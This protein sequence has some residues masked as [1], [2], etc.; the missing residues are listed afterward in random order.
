MKATPIKVRISFRFQTLPTSCERGL[1]DSLL[2]NRSGVGPWLQNFCSHIDPHCSQPTT[3]NLQTNDVRSKQFRAVE[4]QNDKIWQFIQSLPL[5][6]AFGSSVVSFNPS[7]PVFHNLM[8]PFS[9]A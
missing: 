6:T 1:R 8:L 3:P 9:Q 7:A 4:S 2:D 5:R